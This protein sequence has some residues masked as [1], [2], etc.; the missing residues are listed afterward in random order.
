[1]NLDIDKLESELKKR[2]SYP[3]KWGLKQNDELDRQTNFIYKISSFDALIKKAEESFSNQSDKVLLFNYSLNRW[4]NFWSARAVQSFFT[5]HSKVKPVEFSKDREKDFFIND[6]PF[7]HKTSVYPK[8]FRLSHLKIKEN[9]YPLIKWFYRSQSQQ[10]RKHFANRLFVVVYSDSGEHWKIKA[11]L[12]L[13][14]NHINNYLNSFNPDKLIKL[15]FDGR[16]IL[17]DLIMVTR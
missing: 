3:Y 8:K 14:R 11:E 16:E 6:I 15:N 17:S 12:H 7:D 5:S 9:P 2:L 13:L 4:F 1:M 10:Q